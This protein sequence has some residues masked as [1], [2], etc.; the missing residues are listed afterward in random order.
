[1][2]GLS[3]VAHVKSVPWG[4][5]SL[6]HPH[7]GCGQEEPERVEHLA[8]EM[9]FESNRVCRVS[10]SHRRCPSLPWLHH[11][12]CC[13]RT[14]RRAAWGELGSLKCLGIWSGFWNLV[15]KDFF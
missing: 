14:A 11:S 10:P 8:V 5:L 2:S 4:H 3:L 15:L 1:M 7:P 6:A 12:S 13:S 9:N